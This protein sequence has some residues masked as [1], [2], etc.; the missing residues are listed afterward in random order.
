MLCAKAA[1]TTQSPDP[2]PA[3]ERQESSGPSEARSSQMVVGFVLM[4]VP[5]TVVTMNMIVDQIH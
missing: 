2:S 4:H 1:T 3:A 5:Q